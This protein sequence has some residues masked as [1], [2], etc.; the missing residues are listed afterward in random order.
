MYVMGVRKKQV[1]GSDAGVYFA[2]KSLDPS[3]EAA[4]TLIK[5]I[6]GV[7]DAI[8]LAN[9]PSHAEVIMTDDGPCL[10]MVNCRCIGGDAFLTSLA[11]SL[12]GYS[13]LE[14]TA[15]A[16][17]DPDSFFSPMKN[18]DK[19]VF[20]VKT[21]SEVINLVSLSEGIIES[22]P[23]YEKNLKSFFRYSWY[24]RFKSR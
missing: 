22:K 10:V 12:T 3:S 8:G 7:L 16:F 21:F 24:R 15:D 5:Y 9:G 20:P 2:F 6:R 19:S 11:I 13:Q 4:I 14:A 18:P 1:N 23:G 17:L